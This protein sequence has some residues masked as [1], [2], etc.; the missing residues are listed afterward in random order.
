[1]CGL[2]A[3]WGVVWKGR[4]EMSVPDNYS[5]WE[6]H[7]RKQE[8]EQSKYPTCDHCGNPMYEYLFKID[9]EILCEDCVKYLYR[10]EV[11][12]D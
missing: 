10:E 12:L 4:E 3:L 9:E 2:C 5:Q 6:A 11:T 7:E 1:M 8:Q